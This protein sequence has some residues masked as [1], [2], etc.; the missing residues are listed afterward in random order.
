MPKI[1]ATSSTIQAYDPCNSQCLSSLQT[2]TYYGIPPWNGRPATTYGPP[3]YTGS[4]ILI[5]IFTSS[6]SEVMVRMDAAQ[7]W[8][9]SVRDI[10]I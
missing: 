10:T 6:P 5:S 1:R 7:D 2:Q 8:C 3:M 4:F 9:S